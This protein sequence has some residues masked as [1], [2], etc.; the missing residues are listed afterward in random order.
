VQANS[1]AVMTAHDLAPAV[2]VSGVPSASGDR[3]GDILTIPEVAGILRCSL[4]HV[5][6]VINGKVPGVPILPHFIMGR[7]KL[8]RREWL[9]EWLQSYR[10]KC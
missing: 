10:T 9:S 5:S 4:N 8:V 2:D 6:N 7:R 1:S 3:A